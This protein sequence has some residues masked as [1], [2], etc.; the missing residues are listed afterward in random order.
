M[1]IFC[2]LGPASLNKKFL[3]FVEK[4]KYIVS[5]VRI[6][7][8]HVKADEIEK[9]VNFIRKYCSIPICI[10]TEGAQIRAKVNT[11]SKKKIIKKND[12]F[13][14][15]KDKGYFNLYP[16]YI[17]SLIKKNDILNIGFE[18]LLG[19]V[20]KKEKKIIELKA[21]SGGILENNKGVHVENRNVKINFLT[22]KDKVSIKIGKELK[23]NNYA[24]SF[25]NTLSDLKNFQKLLPKSNKIFK[26]ESDKAVK[27]IKNFFK[28]E[29]N[30]LIDRGDLSKSVGIEKIPVIQRD[31]LKLSKKNGA[32]ISIATNFLES[33]IEKSFPT[34]AEVNDIYNALEMGTKNLV[35]AGETAIGKHPEKCVEL[36]ERIIKIFEK[37]GKNYEEN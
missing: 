14:I 1:N 17:F 33:M 30:F 22:N 35:L 3:T 27:N 2:T 10:D 9:I 5:L 12:Y 23:I 16:D 8:S 34:R 13:Y 36:V 19:K 18:G 28:H 4:K 20:I 26:I 15:N 11:K 31:I 21:L 25:T 6:N 32:N 29:K 24:L 37:F 7:L